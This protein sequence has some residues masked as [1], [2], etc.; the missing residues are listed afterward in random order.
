MLPFTIPA[1]LRYMMIS[2]FGF[3][4]MAVCVK[5]AGSY[6]IPVFEIIAARALVSLILSYADVYR[7]INP[8]GT[9]HGLLFARGVIGTI[10]MIGIYYAINTLLWQKRLSAVSLSC[11]Y[12]DIS[13]DLG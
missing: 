13:V 10:A 7:K 2:A 5:E 4:M 8:F 12:S 1:G 9:Q 6:G 3:A 11:L